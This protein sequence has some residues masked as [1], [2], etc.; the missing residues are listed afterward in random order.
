MADITQI[1]IGGTTYNI[2]DADAAH[3]ISGTSSATA[4]T[5][6]VVATASY[7]NGILTIGTI[8][9]AASGHTHPITVTKDS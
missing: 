2:K 3:S 8:G 1:K 9:V 6:T 5:A 7:S 4:A